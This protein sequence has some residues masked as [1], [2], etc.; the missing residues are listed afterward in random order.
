MIGQNKTLALCSYCETY[1]FVEV[2]L[3]IQNQKLCDST[4]IF[5]EHMGPTN[6]SARWTS[7]ISRCPCVLRTP[8]GMMSRYFRK[9]CVSQKRS[10]KQIGN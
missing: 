10:F 3:K 2:S 6:L 1:A 4:G 7:H 9:I 8:G 5:L